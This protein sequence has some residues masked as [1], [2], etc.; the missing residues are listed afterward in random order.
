[1]PAHDALPSLVLM[2]IRRQHLRPQAQA[3]P[4]TADVL[5]EVLFHRGLQIEDVRS[6]AALSL[7][8]L[9]A[10][11]S[12]ELVGL[13]WQQAGAGRGWLRMSA[14]RAELTLLGSKAAPGRIE[15]V[16]VP[17]A[18]N[19]LALQAVNDWIAAAA[20][21]PGT[22]LVRAL[23]R[24]GRVSTTRLHAGSVNV[25]VKRAMARRFLRCGLPL[26][27]AQAQ[28]RRFSSHSG[29]VGLYVSAAVAGVPLQHVAGLARHKGLATAAR[30]AS[31]VDQL[32]CAPHRAT[33]VGV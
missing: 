1:L 7:L 17:A 15:S 8:Y 27:Q 13:D 25:I 24:G 11:R 16:G 2:G 6:G 28:A 3:E 18:V 9:F 29:R 12:S 19:P 20:I 21:A 5:R 33:G 32:K 26:A 22:P 4:L 10:L 31:R 30:Y 23:L 14:D